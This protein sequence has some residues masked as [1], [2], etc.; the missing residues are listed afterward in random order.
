MIVLKNALLV[1]MPHYDSF[2]LGSLLTTPWLLPLKGAYATY[3]TVQANTIAD[4]TWKGKG[5]YYLAGN[6]PKTD[7][8]AF[9]SHASPDLATWN[10][11]LGHIN[12]TS[13]IQ[14]AKKTLCNRYASWP[15]P[16]FPPI[17]EHCIACQTDKKL[18]CQRLEGVSRLK[19]S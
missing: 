18:L 11:H 1:Q 5:L 16:C 6:D 15:I 12:Y 14:M 10:R 8:W 13:I 17:C 19:R 7:E 4:G 9:I 3:T 2:P